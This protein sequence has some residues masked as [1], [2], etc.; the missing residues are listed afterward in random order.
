MNGYLCLSEHISS[1]P[2]IILC[3]HITNVKMDILIGC[4]KVLH[5]IMD[6][7]LETLLVMILV[8][9]RGPGLPVLQYKLSQT[10]NFVS[11]CPAAFCTYNDRENVRI[12]S[13]CCV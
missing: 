7:L 4:G 1:R 5:A 10:C 11:K 9:E 13:M 12:C 3:L 8:K 6:L 2:C